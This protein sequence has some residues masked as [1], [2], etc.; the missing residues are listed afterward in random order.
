M[1]IAQNAASKFSV[2]LVAIAMIFS[3][4]APAVQA[5]TTEELQ[6]MIN[7][8]MAQIA[9]L[10]T[11]SA[12][13][14]VGSSC[15]SIPA[16]LTIGSEGANVT[17]LQ[18]VLITAKYSIPAGAT[19]YFGTQTQSALAAWQAKMGVSPAV[20]YYGPITMAALAAS[21]TPVDMDDEMMDDEDMDDEDMM[22]LQGEGS[23]D[24]VEIDDASDTDIQEGAEDEEIATVTLEATDGDLELSRMDI[25][26]V[27]NTGNEEIDPW[28]VFETISLWVDGDMIAEMTADDE[29]EY[30]D[31]DEGTLRFTNLGL[32][33]M[34]DEEVEIVIAAS[35]QSS[36]D[37]ADMNDAEWNVSVEAIR[38]FDADGVADD[39]RS[40]D[41]IGDSVQFDIVAEGD[42][43]ELKFSLSSGNPDSTDIVVDT[44]NKTNGVTILE[45]TIE[46]KDGDIELN[47]LM[48]DIE[49]LVAGN[50]VIDDVMLEID[51]DTFDAEGSASTTLSN[52]FEFDIDGDVTIDEDDE[53]TVMVMVDFRSQ[54][55][56]NNVDRYTNGTTIKASAYVD[57][58]DAEGADDVNDFTGSAVGDVHTLVAE[59][60]IVPVD[61]FDSETR[62]LGQNDTIGEF[63]LE[64]EVTAVEDDFYIANFASTTAG[65]TTGGVEFEVTGSSIGTGTVS[66]SLDSSADEDTLNVFTVREGE[67]ETFT[68]TVTVD[69]QTT[70]TFRV[71]LQ[72]VWFS[73]NTNGVTGSEEYLVT[74]ASDFRT[75]TRA[76]QG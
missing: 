13:N 6:K 20:G 36:V 9:A 18:N 44:D 37:G 33:L 73:A 15:V 16:P 68:L 43:E 72:E 4:F 57:G 31:E 32:V 2:A 56:S 41:E 71:E 1:T 55:S 40:T 67:T 59:G 64:F 25:A 24:R 21:C 53:V 76:I 38:T 69:P 17:A 29:D 60:I 5:Q 50:L 35:V 51:G 23:L 12:G 8:L 70:G 30:L 54:E 28:D 45:Y 75:G 63:T 48:V 7:D 27:A 39:D 65:V 34:E 19:G 61:G 52:R 66:A 10:Q 46:A 14:P 62:T 42:G 74:P 3:M 22:D 26:L 11:T 49:T 47:T 58:T